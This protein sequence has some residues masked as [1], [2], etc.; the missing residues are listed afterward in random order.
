MKT[1]GEELFFIE[2]QGETLFANKHKMFAN[3]ACIVK[4]ICFLRYF[5]AHLYPK[6]HH[7]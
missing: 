5:L 7:L 3:A 1:G 2:N 6:S 4:R